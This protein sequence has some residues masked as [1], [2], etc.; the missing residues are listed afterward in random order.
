MSAEITIDELHMIYEKLSIKNLL[1][2]LLE[3]TEEYHE[4]VEDVQKEHEVLQTKKALVIML[5]ILL[6]KL[7]KIALNNLYESSEV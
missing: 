6:N 5:N 4:N 3:K 7:D 1:I 2:F